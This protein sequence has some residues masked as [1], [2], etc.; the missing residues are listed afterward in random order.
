MMPTIRDTAEKYEALS[1]YTDF[2]KAALCLMATDATGD[3]AQTAR[4]AKF[5]AKVCDV[6]SKA[7]TSAATTENSGISGVLAP[8]LPAL[9]SQVANAGV[10]DVV[11]ASA[12][13]LPMHIGKVI[14]ASSIQ[15]NTVAE[16]AAK[17]VFGLTLN[18][19][20]FEPIKI[21]SSFVL[22]NE[23]AR[24]MGPEAVRIIGRELPR[25][26]AIGTDTAFLAA[27]PGNS[28]EAMGADS[29]DGFSDDLA[30][31]MRMVDG[32][33]TSRLFLIVPA[34]IGKQLAAKGLTSGL[35]LSWNG[36]TVA[37]VEMRV[38][39]AQDG[40]RITLVAADG[41]AI[42]QTP[43]ELRTSTHAAVEMDNAPSSNSTT[44]TSVSMV[45]MFQVDCRCLLA[46]REIGIKAIRPNSYAHLTG[47]ALG[48]GAGSPA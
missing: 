16:G 25:A 36:G 18:T 42:A 14:I 9:M 5:N 31:L 11:A 1:S 46:E 45:S 7:A 29:L 6:L 34:T 24:R 32:G 48:Q 3:P 43:I 19:S 23:L 26:V 2:A 28:H 15:S 37:G 20:D 4:A 33:A 12:L 10:F 41:L 13:R 44:P 8:L 35:N 22:S 27:L 40:G 38:S 39:D 30:E 21:V 47:V 17:P